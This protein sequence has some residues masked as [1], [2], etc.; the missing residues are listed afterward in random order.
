MGGSLQQKQ[1]SEAHTIRH[2]EHYGLSNHQ[3]YDCLLNR[4]FRRRFKKKIKL[5]VIGLCEGNSL[6]T[7]EFPVQRVSN[8]E[9][10]SIWRRHHLQVH[11]KVLANS[12][13]V[14]SICSAFGLA[15]WL[16]S[17][18]KSPKRPTVSSENVMY[19]NVLMTLLDL[20]VIICGPGTSVTDAI[21]C[22]NS[23]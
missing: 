1:E 19:C 3:P 22:K 8:A 23:C 14:V 18:Y 9:N 16:D 12:E 15:I 7:G 6:V 11:L 4:L 17:L 20:W 10:V 5:R 2:N 21:A 13:K